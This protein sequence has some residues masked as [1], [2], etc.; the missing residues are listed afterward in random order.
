VA[1]GSDEFDLNRAAQIVRAG[2]KA[3][4]ASAG[5]SDSEDILQQAF[6]V[7]IQKMAAGKVE[8]QNL[9]D[10]AQMRAFLF[11]AIKLI[12]L[13][14]YRDRNINVP[15]EAVPEVQ[16]DAGGG[17]AEEKKQALQDSI[18]REALDQLDESD[19]IEAKAWLQGE[20]I[21]AAA[22]RLRVSVD[23]AKTRRQRAKERLIQLALTSKRWRTWEDLSALFKRGSSE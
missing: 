8:A 14:R 16:G 18:I 19:R 20:S 12:R 17:Y 1:S 6:L 7:M 9:S 15:I 4:L 2:L 11:A 5:L 22:D 21:K 10:P 3:Y 23:V 13:E